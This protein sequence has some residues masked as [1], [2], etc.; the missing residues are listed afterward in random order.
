M[1]MTLAMKSLHVSCMQVYSM[2]DCEKYIESAGLII[3]EYL[4]KYCF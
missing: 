1:C 4:I 3:S 2:F